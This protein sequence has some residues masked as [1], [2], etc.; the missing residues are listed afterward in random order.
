MTTSNRNEDQVLSQLDSG[1]A[2]RL[3]CSHQRRSNKDR[4]H[5]F[6]AKSPLR[7]Q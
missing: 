2:Y 4:N 1:S 7:K 5:R 3:R 6:K